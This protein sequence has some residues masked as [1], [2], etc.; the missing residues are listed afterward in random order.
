MKYRALIAFAAGILAASST[1]S[2]AKL[3]VFGHARAVPASRALPAPYHWTQGEAPKAQR[4]MVAEFGKVGLAPGQYVWASAISK[5]GETK[6]VIDRLTQM[7]YVY[8]ADKLVGAA[9][10]ST[11]TVGRITPLGFWSVL[12]KRPF[13]RS[14]K[15]DNAPM[16]FMQRIDD[17]GIA[18]HAGYNPGEPASHG[19]IRLP[20]KFASKLYQVTGVGTPV[21]IGA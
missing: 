18:M 1:A 20:A 8:R 10:V 14:K 5:Q 9:T 17:Y 3:R 16:P 21:L 4:D 12:E 15:Y 11:A 13:Y 7:A 6:I 2:E 19:C